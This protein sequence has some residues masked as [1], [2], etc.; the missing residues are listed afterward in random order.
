MQVEDVLDLWAKW[1]FEHSGGQAN[2]LYRLMRGIEPHPLKI[3]DIPY[4][5]DKD[6]IFCAIDAAVCALP[7]IR[8][9][10]LLLE[11]TQRGTQEQKARR[12]SPAL[13]RRSFQNQLYLAHAQIARLP[14]VKKLL[15]NVVV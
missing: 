5:V 3:S 9:Q 7:P 6:G 13:T 2:I 8:R 12:C 15:D 4:G 11:Y 14:C 1:R 10:V